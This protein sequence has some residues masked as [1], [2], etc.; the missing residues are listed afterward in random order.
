M[1]ESP[2]DTAFLRFCAEG[3]PQAL[4]D[5][6]NFTAPELLRVAAHLMRSPDTAEDLLTLWT[7]TVA[8]FHCLQ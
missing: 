8:L 6:F 4:G 3:D 5:V 1:P 7:V 2:A